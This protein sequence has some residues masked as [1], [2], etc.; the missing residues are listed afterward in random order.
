MKSQF[1]FLR[2]KDGRT[3][4]ARVAIATDPGI[5]G[6]QLSA[7]AGAP[8]PNTPERWLEAARIGAERALH[9]HVELGGSRVGL[10]VTSVLGTEVDTTE[11][12]IEVA[13]FCAT[14]EALEH[15]ETELKFEFNR[16]WQVR[17]LT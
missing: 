13:A 7:N 12:T 11:S 16:E 5:E 17:R 9:A 10:M 1:N 15:P 4:F 6:V 2:V 3:Y 14:W 8:N